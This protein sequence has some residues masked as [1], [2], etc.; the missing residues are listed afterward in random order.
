MPLPLHIF[1]ERYKIMIGECLDQNREFGVVYYNGNQMRRIGC[2]A[3]IIKVLKRYDD[4]RMDIM[5]RGGKRFEIVDVSDSKAYL[6]S[7]I[8]Y[9]ADDVE[10]ET[11]EFAHLA[12]EGIDLL[13]QLE[14]LT[15][16][17]V[18]TSFPEK[19]DLKLLSFLIPSNDG[20]TLE[21]KQRFLEM[22]S[23]ADRLRKS[24]E[25]LRKIVGRTQIT[26]DI[27][28]MIGGNGNVPKD[29]IETKKELA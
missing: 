6:Q 2:T 15:G 1:E 9:L 19:P 7:R 22:T 3:R 13:K 10:D 5:T 8:I 4:G 16:K 23:R 12:T 11:E 28:R 26:Q 27:Q 20:F 25:S 17:K 14:G 24:V 21:E 18:E 29:L